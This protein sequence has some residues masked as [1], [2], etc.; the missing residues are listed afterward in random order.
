ME[1]V[2]SSRKTE[3]RMRWVINATLLLFLIVACAVPPA[4]VQTKLAQWRQGV[5]MTEDGSY[6]VYTDSH[7]FVLYVSGDS[8]S[9]N[10]Y[11]AAS[12]VR[13]HKKGMARKQVLRFRQLPG[14]QP[15]LFNEGKLQPD[16]S[17]PPMTIDTSLFA[18]GVCNIRDGVIYDSITEEADDYILLATCNGDHEKIFSN[19]VSVYLPASGGEFYS[20]RIESF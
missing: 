7:Y 12:Q 17:E 2:L 8:S 18:P 10:I 5:W 3:D 4:D 6:T 14:I 1:F 19:G 9:P 16:H 20:Y 15:V 13:F 11:C